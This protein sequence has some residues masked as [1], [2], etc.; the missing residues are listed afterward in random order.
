MKILDKCSNLIHRVGRR[1]AFLL[2][3][4]LVDFIYGYSILLIANPV[5]SRIDLFLPSVAWGII[6]IAVGFICLV[7]A[8]FTIDRL[9][10]SLAVG[11]KVVWSLAMFSSWVFTGT[12]PVGWV[13]GTLFLGF[14]AITSI[15]SYW[16]E[17]RDFNLGD[18]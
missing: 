8:F 10:Y 9:A 14:A 11:T 3:L 4:A 13:S 6:W 12:N 2:F 1:G 15:V 16:P 7:Q 18:F 5:W 17:H